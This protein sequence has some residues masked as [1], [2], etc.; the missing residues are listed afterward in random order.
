[1]NSIR[2]SLSLGDRSTL[3]STTKSHQNKSN[4]K[5]VSVQKSFISQYL[6]F[7]SQSCLLESTAAIFRQSAGFV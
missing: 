7:Q 6:F 2:Y 4:L 3:C 5:N 1:M